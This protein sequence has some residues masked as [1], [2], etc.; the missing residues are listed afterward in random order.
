MD[1]WFKGVTSANF[2]IAA[3]SGYLYRQGNGKKWVNSTAE[4]T[5]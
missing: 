3:E 5:D 1:H 4:S 2:W